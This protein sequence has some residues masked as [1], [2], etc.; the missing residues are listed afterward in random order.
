MK[1]KV[2]YSLKNE[3]EKK[4]DYSNDKTIKLTLEEF[5]PPFIYKSLYA[6]Q[7]DGIKKGLNLFGRVMINDDF[8]CGKSLQ[9]LTL[10]LAYKNEWPLLILCPTFVRYY[11]R[12]EILKWF[13][14]FDLKKT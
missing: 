6:F 11:W 3:R 8:G 7:R 9:A 2:P 13:P 14:G 5:V 1:T 12:Y 10:S 4:H